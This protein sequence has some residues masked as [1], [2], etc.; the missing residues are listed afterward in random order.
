M[1]LD[2]SLKW[3]ALLL[4]GGEALEASEGFVN[5]IV[6]HQVTSGVDWFVT[7]E[8]S[9]QDQLA[10]YPIEDGGARFELWSTRQSPRQEYLLDHQ[11]VG[12]YV[13][14]AQVTITSQD[15]Y[16]TVPRT[17]ADQPFTVTV[18]VSGMSL[19][20]EA[21]TAART[22]NL[23]RH[24]QS[25]GPDG[26]GLG[27]DRSGATL[28]S[29][30]SL[31]SDGHETRVFDFV[32]DLSSIPGA[33][34]SK[35]RGEERITVESLPDY[36]V[37]AAQLGSMYIQVWPVADGT[38][39]GLEEDQQLRFET[40]ALTVELNDLYPDSLTYVQVYEGTEDLGREGVV[41]GGSAIAINDAVP[42]DRVLVIKDWDKVIETSGVYTMEILTET[43]FGV[44]R[45]DYLTFGI[46]RDIEVNSGV[47]TME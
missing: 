2:R 35:I 34:R 45:L 11:Y 31:S 36:Q 29:E 33:D 23:M 27:I 13:P 39:K 47:S 22:V 42:Q 41:I 44:D 43:P 17:R 6:Q 8:P 24:V 37:Y 26:D 40:P 19:N 28:L 16:V 15:P 32:Y 5:Q 7:V 21:P 30:G 10:P 14:Q 3:M 12:T 18:T 20:P 1:N 9:G 46:D 38:L 4:V 25:Y